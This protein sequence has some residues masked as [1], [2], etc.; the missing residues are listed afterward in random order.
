MPQYTWQRIVLRQT[1]VL[2]ILSWKLKIAVI[3][4]ILDS[5]LVRMVIP[6]IN[7]IEVE[8]QKQIK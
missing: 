7:I 5:M 2:M 4:T 1:F 3:N 8:I 6:C